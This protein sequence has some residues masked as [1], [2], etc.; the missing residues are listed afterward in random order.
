MDVR[1]VCQREYVWWIRQ[2]L[3]FCV[4]VSV[5]CLDSVRSVVI[6]CYLFYSSIMMMEEEDDIQVLVGAC[7]LE[8]G[9]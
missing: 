8:M 4:V 5:V 6:Y 7:G 2:Q 1:Y 9:V 3:V